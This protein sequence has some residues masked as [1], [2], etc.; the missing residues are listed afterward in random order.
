MSSIRELTHYYAGVWKRPRVSEYLDVIN[1]GGAAAIK[2]RYEVPPGNIG[3]NIGVAAPMA[4]FPFS[5]WRDSS[6][7]YST[8]KDAMQFYTDKKV[9]VERWP[10]EWSREFCTR[11]RGMPPA[12]YAE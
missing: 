7:T 9:V 6:Q 2:F 10:K 12:S 4:Y 5:G 3:I 11:H 8:G 1:P